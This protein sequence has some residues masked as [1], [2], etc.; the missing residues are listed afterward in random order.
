MIG[1]SLLIKESGVLIGLGLGRAG[2]GRRDVSEVREEEAETIL[3]ALEEME[4]EHCYKMVICA[5]AA[6]Q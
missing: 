4:P 3:A 5:A 2:I 1:C 6:G